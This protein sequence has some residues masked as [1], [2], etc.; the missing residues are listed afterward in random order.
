MSAEIPPAVISARPA[1][2]IPSIEGADDSSRR[3]AIP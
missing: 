1:V 2:A 3:K